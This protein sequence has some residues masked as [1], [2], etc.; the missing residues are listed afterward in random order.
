MSPQ[1][2]LA[3]LGIPERLT[4]SLPSE[5]IDRWVATLEVPP[6]P[7]D[8][9]PLLW[10]WAF[11]TPSAPASTLGEDGH[12]RVGERLAELGLP[13]RMFAGGSS[14]LLQPMRM[15]VATHRHA[16]MV[17]AEEK[18]GRSG[19]LLIVTVEYDYEQHSEVVL[20]E[21]QTLVYRE[22]GGRMALP[23]GD[24]AAEREE[25]AWREHRKL[26]PATLMR[27]S[28]LTFNAHRIH[29][30]QPYADEVE[31][32]P[33]LVVHGPL[34]AVLGCELGRKN[35]GPLASVRF[36]ALAPVFEGTTFAV[37]GEAE[38]GRAAVTIVR[39]DGASA[40]ELTVGTQ[41]WT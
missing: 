14:S 21:Q 28:A 25:Y 19:R 15:D 20:R 27:F 30:D 26:D 7:S 10:H 16:R 6:P 13:R 9:L 37:E 34:L 11:F 5:Q 36:R 12:P 38:D 8:E 1:L 40:M 33:R 22:A 32:Y 39:N 18:A 41:P 2:Q 17:G 24:Q 3:D 29:Y 4:S 31:G 23:E 35:L